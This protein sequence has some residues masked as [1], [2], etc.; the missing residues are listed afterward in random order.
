MEKQF[1]W[2]GIIYI[3]ATTNHVYW[4]IIQPSTFYKQCEDIWL[5]QI[6]Y[7]NWDPIQSKFLNN[8]NRIPAVTVYY[9]LK[10]TFYWYTLGPKLHYTLKWKNH[11]RRSIIIWQP[12]GQWLTAVST[13]EHSCSTVWVL[14]ADSL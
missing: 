12:R 7:H 4:V 5:L 13:D 6:P 14:E 1:S 8:I 9:K 10:V 3:F 11:S 2:A